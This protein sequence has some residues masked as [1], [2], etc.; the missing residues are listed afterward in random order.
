M[1]KSCSA[2]KGKTMNMLCRLG[3]HISTYHDSAFFNS[4]RRCNECGAGLDRKSEAEL[5][6]ERSLWNSVPDDISS[7]FS[8]RALWVYDELR[9]SV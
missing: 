8:A 3:I 6:R 5:L 2:R 9:K 1:D 4:V 7:D